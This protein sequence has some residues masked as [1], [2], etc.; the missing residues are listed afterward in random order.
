MRLPLRVHRSDNRA[1]ERIGRSAEA[2]HRRNAGPFQSAMSML[3]FEIN[4]GGKN[5]S[6]ERLQVLEQAKQELRRLLGRPL[7]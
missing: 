5:L 1:I 2:S 6:P 7:E 3:N 4:R